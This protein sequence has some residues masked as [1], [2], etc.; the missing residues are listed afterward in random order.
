[1]LECSS[2]QLETLEHAATDV[3]MV[4]NI[5][6]DHLDRYPTLD[7]YAATKA[8]VFTGLHAGGLALLDAGDGWTAF[9]R[10]RVGAGRL[11]LVDDP[12]G[13]RIVGP[14]PGDSLVLPGGD[15]FRA[16]PCRS[17]AATTARTPC[18]PCSPPATSAS[19]LPP[20]CAASRVSTACPTA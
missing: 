15:S 7:D 18:S 20:A 8:R 12:G 10:A 4:L 3:A 14:G 2:F 17:P 16:G 19:T 5:T 6:P 13:A 1:M 9:L 11:V